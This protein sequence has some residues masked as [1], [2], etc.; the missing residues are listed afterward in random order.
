[1]TQSHYAFVA[2]QYGPRANAYVDSPVHASG[3]DLDQLEMLVRDYPAA[4]VL[5]L[6]CGGGHVTYRA[7][8]HVAAV[9]ACDITQEMVETVRANAE[10][11]ALVNVTTRQGAAEAL[12]FEDAAFDLVLSRFSA[13]HW[14]DLEVGLRE[15]RRVLKSGSRALF[16]D[17][18]A[19]PSALLD[20]H[21]QT[22]E[23]LRDP[24][25]VRDYTTAEWAGALGRVGFAIHSIRCYTLRM[26][27]RSWTE[28]TRTSPVYVAA[29]QA[30]QRGAAPEVRRHFAVD[31]DGSFDLLSV[32]LEVVAV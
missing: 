16:I 32:A 27:F 23:L 18:Q 11:R 14:H 7:A 20:T 29:I 21:L 8:P 6:G 3:A 22:I 24:S 12:P 17:S 15:A 5:D 4:R 25:H 10:R 31:D 30:L 9:V 26:E 13:H 1:M 2:D 19:P 28:R